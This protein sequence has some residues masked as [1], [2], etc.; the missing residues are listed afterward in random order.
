M[1]SI[2][3][4]NISK[5]KNCDISAPQQYLNPKRNIC[6][7]CTKS[8]SKYKCPRCNVPYCSLK[9]YKKHDVDCTEEFY[10]EWVEE[11]MKN[12]VDKKK[13]PI[14][15]DVN[16]NNV[17][18]IHDETIIEREERR[19]EILK[20]LLNKMKLGQHVDLNDLDTN[21]KNKFIA[22]ITDGKLSKDIK[23]WVPWWIETLELHN[24]RHFIQPSKSFDTIKSFCI[25]CNT[26]YLSKP[27]KIVTNSEVNMKKAKN[28]SQFENHI[29]DVIF[30]YVAV[31]KRYN[32]KW[33]IDSTSSASLFLRLSNSL[34][35]IKSIFTV[36]EVANNFYC[37]Y[38]KEFQYE[39]DLK[40]DI[41]NITNDV[42]LILRY[43]H[44][45]LDVL[46]D[47]MNI[48]QLAITCCKKCDDDITKKATRKK[49]KFARKKIIYFIHWVETSTIEE[50]HLW[51]KIYSKLSKKILQLH[52]DRLEEEEEKKLVAQ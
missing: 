3:K 1:S 27:N 12:N 50:S 38:F 30:V 52:I 15:K 45:V 34:E 16:N 31:I 26:K 13:K 40:N 8:T 19:E 23:Q 10:K 20:S 5:I 36:E 32:G 14:F 42:Q 43:K 11:E 4:N 49:Y 22:E 21:D 35:F 39:K 44:Y 28:I 2:I 46:M 6:H 17:D 48:F 37:N 33:N 25:T 7:V 18:I 47:V 51:D 29:L 41:I 9:C 24:K